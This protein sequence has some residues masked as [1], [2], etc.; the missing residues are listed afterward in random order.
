MTLPPGVHIFVWSPPTLCR[1]GL[2]GG[3][4]RPGR[5]KTETSSQQPEGKGGLPKNHM[6]DLESVFSS[7][8]LSLEMP[9]AQ[10]DSLTESPDT[11]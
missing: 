7:P 5:Q 10:A 6:N 2:S 1:I 4:A 8:E 3:E 9:L 11:P